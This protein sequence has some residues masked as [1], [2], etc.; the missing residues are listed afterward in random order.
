MQL[1]LA[2]AWNRI[3]VAK[4]EIFTDDKRWTV[5]FMF[6]QVIR[7]LFS[8]LLFSLLF[9]SLLFSR[10][11]IH[12]KVD[13]LPTNFGEG[14]IFHFFFFCVFQASGGLCK[15]RLRGARIKHE[16]EGA[17]KSEIT[18]L[19]SCARPFVRDQDFALTSHL[20]SSSLSLAWIR[21]NAMAVV[22]A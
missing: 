4:S 8:S 10:E 19:F 1:N 11:W 3:D 14:V 12:V 22:H 20:P 18:R 2:L 17:K 15:A 5:S 16:M 21:Q 6:S 9:S 13:K 7:L